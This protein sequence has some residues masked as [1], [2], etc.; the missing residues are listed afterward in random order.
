M[1]GRFIAPTYV[2]EHD[3]VIRPHLVVWLDAEGEIVER[4]IVRPDDQ[5]NALAE[6]LRAAVNRLLEDGG[7]P[8]R[9]ARVATAE[10]AALLTQ[11]FGSKLQV[12]VG[13]T[14]ELDRAV[15]NLGERMLR[16]GDLGAGRVVHRPSYLEQGRVPEPLVAE[17]FARAAELHRLE[18]WALAA[19]SQLLLVHAP[20]LGLERACVSVLGAASDH[21]GFLL[22]DSVEAFDAFCD[23]IEAWELGNTEQLAGGYLG[24]SFV[25]DSTLEMPFGR[26]L[27]KHRWPTVGPRAIPLLASTDPDGVSRP[28]TPSDYQRALA[29]IGGLERF[30]A[31]HEA[32][33]TM[34]PPR[35]CKTKAS[36][37]VAGTL[38]EVTV[39]GP[40]PDAPWVRLDE[41]ESE[42]E[43]EHDAGEDGY[44]DDDLDEEAGG[45]D[46]E[47]PG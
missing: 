36:L 35:P 33:F 6:V 13:T 40:H 8:P 10:E 39:E 24:L 41:S 29:V 28:L 21:S 45:E 14:R 9:L 31:E 22:F 30:L 47:T 19:E 44:E 23:G 3:A 16:A 43:D 4:A 5:P 26:E 2:V 17:L 34:D 38:H 27:A 7:K 12:Q 1:G 32:L 11:A 42:D 46:G 20:T 15:L 37:S 18:P 25:A